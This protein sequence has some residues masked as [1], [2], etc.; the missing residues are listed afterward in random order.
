[1]S[2]IPC[3]SR[4]QYIGAMILWTGARRRRRTRSRL[5]AAAGRAGS[6]GRMTHE[7]EEDEDSGEV[8]R[9]NR[10][11]TSRGQI[12][13]GAPPPARG[14]SRARSRESKPIPRA[15]ESQKPTATTSSPQPGADREPAPATMIAEVSASPRLD[16][17]DIG[18]HQE[19]ER[20]G[21]PRERIRRQRARRP[22]FR[23]SLKT[24]ARRATRST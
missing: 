24:C 11:D 3:A 14:T 10:T 1:L 8:T 15:K 19:V 23:R 6:S 21:A 20:I 5:P 7:E 13:E 9:H 4:Q 22:M 2:S 18:P 17:L 12:L 16:Y